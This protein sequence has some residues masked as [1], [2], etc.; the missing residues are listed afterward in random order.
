MPESA[1]ALFGAIAIVLSIAIFVPYIRAIRGG[2]TRPHVFTWLIWALVTF[3]VFLAQLAAG[4]GFGAWPIGVSGLI[5]IYVAL[6]AWR[7]HG[8]RVITRSDRWF[9]GLALAAL[10]CWWLSADPLWAVV[11]LTGVDLAGFGPTFRAA[12]ARP[13]EEHSGF[14]ALA[15]LRNALV[16]LAL[17]RQVLATVLF[18]AVVGLVCLLL[19]AMI[20]YRRHVLEP[21][22]AAA[23]TPDT[24]SPA[25]AVQKR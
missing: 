18:P 17:E 4:G 12:Y 25:A 5:T 11:I 9:L 21:R 16:I 6:L 1:R 8:D 22:R 10:P 19:V 3:V 15:A 24:A 14:Y 13:H 20:L 7:H 2:R 23:A